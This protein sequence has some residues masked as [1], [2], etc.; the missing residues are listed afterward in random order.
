MLLRLQK[1]DIDLTYKPG[2]EMLLADTLSRAHLSGTTEEV[3]EE[4]MIAHVHMVSSSKSIPDKQMILIKEKTKKDE[5]LQ[6]LIT[7]IEIGWPNN[8]VI[9]AYQ[10]G[11]VSCW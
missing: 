6:R 1:Y 11:I 9:L 4:E 10:R 7:Y 5:E 2:K 8:R 3:N